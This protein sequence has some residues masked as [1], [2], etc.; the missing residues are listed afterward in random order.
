M[1]QGQLSSHVLQLRKSNLPEGDD[2]RRRSCMLLQPTCPPSPP[3]IYRSQG[4]GFRPD[5]PRASLNSHTPGSPGG[6]PEVLGCSVGTSGSRARRANPHPHPS[7]SQAAAKLPFVSHCSRLL[8]SHGHV[9]LPARGVPGSTPG[10]GDAPALGQPV[11]CWLPA[12][13]RAPYPCWAQGL[14][15]SSAPGRRA[16]SVHSPRRPAALFS[17]L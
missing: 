17:L 8:Q 2:E 13:P 16:S 9:A 14:P 12:Q 7:P 15:S 3:R 10:P 4:S 5:I 11:G 1:V 6:S